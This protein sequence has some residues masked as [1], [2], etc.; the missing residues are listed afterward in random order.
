M[1]VTMRNI[2]G[3]N[4]TTTAIAGETYNLS[5]GGA[6]AAATVGVAVNVSLFIT[7]IITFSSVV[8]NWRLQ[9]SDDNATF[10]D[11]QLWRHAADGTIAFLALRTPHHIIGGANVVIRVQVLGA[12]ADVNAVGTTGITLRGYTTP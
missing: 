5:L 8:I 1:A 12:A 11:L 7:D 6:A 10:F 4:A 2:V 3:R 9:R